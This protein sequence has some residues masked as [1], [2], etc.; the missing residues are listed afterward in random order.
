MQACKPLIYLSPTSFQEWK[1]CPPKFFLKRLSGYRIT[2]NQ[3][4][5]AAVGCAFDLYIKRYVAR[6]LGILD[7]P[8]LQMDVL[9]HAVEECHD[10]IE[11]LEAGKNIAEK[12]IQLGFVDRLL[13]EGIQD[14][15]LELFEEFDYFNLLGKPD[16]YCYKGNNLFVVPHDWKVRGYK[17]KHGYSPTPGYKVYVTNNGQSFDAHCR[18]GEPLE[19]LNEGWAIQLAIYGW[20]LNTWLF[21]TPDCRLHDLKLQDMPVSIDEVTYGAKSIA[22]TQIR[23][24]ITKT[25]QE[26]LFHS[27]VH[28]WNNCANPPDPMPDPKICHKYNI[29]CE[30]SPYCGAYQQTLGR[31]ELSVLF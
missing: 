26:N 14:V 30:A 31:K 3:G 22:F 6:K 13:D 19:L 25:F 5:P 24:H 10:R 1:L 7:R 2:T 4:R 29:V 8:N 23:T 12:Y 27:L 15:E 20:L 9:L 17:S 18:V 21:K 28:C 16:A 11:L